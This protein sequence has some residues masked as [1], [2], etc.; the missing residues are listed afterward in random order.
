MRIVHKPS[1]QDYWSTDWL[2]AS[3]IFNT[4]MSRNRFLAILKFFY[5][6]T[7][8]WPQ[9]EMMWLDIDYTSWRPLLNHFNQAFQ[10][11]ELDIWFLNNTFLK[12]V[13]GWVS[14]YALRCL[15]TRT[16]SS[17]M[18]LPA[19]TL[20][21]EQ[22]FGRFSQ[23]KPTSELIEHCSNFLPFLKAIANQI[24]AEAEKR[25]KWK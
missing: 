1:I 3:T 21:C 9:T 5:S 10:D 22:N 4:I 7:M 8:T 2:Q 24:T 19:E 12:N 23:G 13:L 11:N 18:L 14:N 16:I 20:Q 6:M 25:K 17:L 15:H